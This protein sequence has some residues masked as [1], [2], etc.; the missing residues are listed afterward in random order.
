ML[1]F[2]DLII[3]D[4]QTNQWYYLEDHLYTN[5]VLRSQKAEKKI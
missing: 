4:W 1:F 5:M 3:F 2:V